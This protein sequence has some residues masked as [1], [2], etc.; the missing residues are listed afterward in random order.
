MMR[1]MN[2]QSSNFFAEV[3]GKS[4]AVDGGHRPGT[5]APPRIHPRSALPV[6]SRARPGLDIPEWEQQLSAGAV[7]TEGTSRRSA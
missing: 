2:R 6:V 7:C 1:F 4:L 3:L 5:I